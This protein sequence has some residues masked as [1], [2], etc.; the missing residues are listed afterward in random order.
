[1]WGDNTWRDPETAAW[2]IVD[3]KVPLYICIQNPFA[4]VRSACYLHMTYRCNTQSV[5]TKVPHLDPPL[6]HVRSESIPICYLDII[7]GEC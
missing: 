6:V 3:T 7:Q 5:G 2:D 4:H 1:M